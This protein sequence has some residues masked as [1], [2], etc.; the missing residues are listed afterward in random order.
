MLTERQRELKRARD[1]RY[2]ERKKELARRSL[3]EVTVSISDFMATVD[4]DPEWIRQNY[5][6]DAELDSALAQ[7]LKGEDD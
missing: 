6:L 4:A 5:V 1:R 7:L 3:T 2:R